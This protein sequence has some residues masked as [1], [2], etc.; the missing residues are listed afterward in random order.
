M[1][2]P[3]F[4][5]HHGGGKAGG[6]AS[7]QG[8]VKSVVKAYQEGAE[9]AEDSEDVLRSEVH[10]QAELIKDLKAKLDTVEQQVTPPA[11]AA[12]AAPVA[13]AAVAAPQEA[14]VQAK[15][16]AGA[17]TTDADYQHWD[18]AYY[19]SDE[20]VWGQAKDESA[21]AAEYMGTNMAF[22][23]HAKEDAKARSQQHVME[24]VG[25]NQKEAK[26]PA[27]ERVEEHAQAEEK[28]EVKGHAATEVKGDAKPPLLSY[29]MVNICETCA[30]VCLVVCLH[31]SVC[32]YIYIYVY[33]Y[34]HTHFY[35]RCKYVHK[36]AVVRDA[37][38]C[39]FFCARHDAVHASLPH[40]LA[41]AFS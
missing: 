22:L 27:E 7:G 36:N 26:A 4:Q 33:I 23:G 24:A 39:E 3:E 35:Y 38:V 25:I 6:D 1:G 40:T 5:E 32:L 9:S 17:S 12:A 30:S 10:A 15:E 8:A 28:D 14:V 31:I 34:T 11:A 29:D 21:D 2:D 20:K 19:P 41:C 37:L 13:V 16:H 18:A